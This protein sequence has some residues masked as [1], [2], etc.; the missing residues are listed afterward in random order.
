M[1]SAKEV[2]KALIRLLPN[3]LGSRPLQFPGECHKLETS[4]KPPLADE[5]FFLA[6]DRRTSSPANA[7]KQ[8]FQNSGMKL[9]KKPKQADLLSALANEVQDVDLDQAYTAPVSPADVSHVE[10]PVGPDLD[11]FDKV[12]Q[13]R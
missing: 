13:E 11:V 4:Q 2:D 6:V 12:D 3:N 7:S 5:R 10:P 1:A 9:G 8:A